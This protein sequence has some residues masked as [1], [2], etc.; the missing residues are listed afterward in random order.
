METVAIR[1]RRTLAV[2]LLVLAAFLA[3]G[4]L[5]SNASAA[6]RHRDAMLSLTNEDRASHHVHSLALDASLSKYARRHSRDMAEHGGL[7]HTADLAAKLKGLDWSIGGENVG[8][9]SS[10]DGLEKAFMHSTDHR[11]NILRKTFDHTAIGV[12]K[13]ADGHFWVTVIFYG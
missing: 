9:G 2:S 1:G 10:L 13:D 3:Q 5:A 7:F 4:V 12:I 8:V 11:R 6:T